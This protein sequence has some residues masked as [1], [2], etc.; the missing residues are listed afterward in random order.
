M[1]ERIKQTTCIEA[2]KEEKKKRQDQDLL[3]LSSLPRVAF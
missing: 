2:M 3:R 1:M